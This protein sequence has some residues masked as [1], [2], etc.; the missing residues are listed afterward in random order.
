MN[1]VYYFLMKLCISFNETFFYLNCKLNKTNCTG[2]DVPSQQRA[3]KKL[4]VS[5]TGRTPSPGNREREYKLRYRRNPLQTRSPDTAEM[6][7]SE[8]ELRNSVSFIYNTCNCI[9]GSSVSTT[10]AELLALLTLLA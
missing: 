1:L 2:Y 8:S 6:P 9:S 10:L 3:V 7:E 4:A 5:I